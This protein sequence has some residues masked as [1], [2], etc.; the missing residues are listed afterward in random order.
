MDESTSDA[1]FF[2]AI[3]F[4][5]SNVVMTRLLRDARMSEGL[6]IKS[7]ARMGIIKWRSLPGEIIMC[8]TNNRRIGDG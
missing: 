5:A 6:D 4:S 1:F 3:F 2:S 8:K 7:E